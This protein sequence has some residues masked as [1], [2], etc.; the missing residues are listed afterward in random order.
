[1]HNILNKKGVLFMKKNCGGKYNASNVAAY[2]INKFNEKGDSLDHLKLQKLLYLIAVKWVGEFKEYPYRQPTEMWKLGPVIREIYGEYR[3]NGSGNIKSPATN[4]SF[5]DGKI[6]LEEATSPD[7]SENEMAL[8]D[9]VI[10]LYGKRNSFDLVDLTHTHNP[11][12]NNEDKIKRND[13]E[14]LEYSYNDFEEIL[15]Q[16]G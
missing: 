8:V 6:K 4:L 16:L 12:K 3:S 5:K 15:Q 7:F 2:I 13:G 11:W 10:S 14:L 1:M 9:Q